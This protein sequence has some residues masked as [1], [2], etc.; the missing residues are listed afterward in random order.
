MK[1]LLRKVWPILFL[2]GLVVIFN[3]KYFFKGLIP[4]PGD[5]LVGAYFPWL[6]YKWG[7][8]VGVAIKNT[9]ISD[10]FSEFYM[11]KVNIA[12]AIVNHQ[13]PAWDPYFYSGFPLFAN[14]NIGAF[15]PFNFLMII[16]NKMDG[17]S[18]LVLSQSLFSSI[19]MY[20]FLKKI[21]KNTY[22]SLIGSIIYAFGGFA[23]AWSQFVNVGFAMIWL[24]LIFFLI[25]QAKSKKNYHILLFLTPL[26]FLTV[27]AGHFQALVYIVVLTVL[28]FVF[29]IGIKN[30]KANIYFVIASI[31]AI[32]VSSIQLLPT[33]ELL[34]LSIR[35]NDGSIR[36]CNFG[37]LPK[38][39]LITLIAPDYFGNPS[40]GNFWGFYNY[41]ETITYV[42]ILSLI[43]W[44]YGIYNYKKLKVG[45][46]FVFSSV[47]A[48]L[49][50][51][52]T[53]LG[54]AV[55]L[56]K[57]PFLWTSVAGRVTMVFL[58]SVSVLTALL[59]K[60]LESLKI[61]DLL[62]ILWAPVLLLT[63]GIVA[64]SH[65]DEINKL[66]ALRNLIL[67]TGLILIISITLIAGTKY[68]FLKY[69]L[70]LIV[71]FDLF[72]FGWKYLPFVPKTYIFPETDI[73]S[74]LKQD[75]TVFRVDKE[76]GPILPPNTWVGYDLM[77][78]SGYDPLAVT[79]YVKAYDYDL[80]GRDG[81]VSRYS[82]IDVYG[83]E[84]L[85]E[86]NVK[87]LLAVKRDEKGRVPGNNVD[88]RIGKDEWKRVFETPSVAVLQNTKYKK[89][90]RIINDDGTDAHGSVEIK[91]YENNK[92]IIDFENL[93]GEKLLL[94]D[95]Y[96]PGWVATINGQKVKIGNEIKPF[97]T[98]N[99]EDVKKGRV[100]FEYKPESYILGVK[101][102]LVSLLGWL[103]AL[104][105]GN[106]R[107]NIADH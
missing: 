82:E 51:F 83:A 6:E 52:D 20:V 46:F 30:T 62:K 60:N 21:V 18:L 29:R 36:G 39:N 5:L 95:T 15:N 22:A 42:G 86:Y 17:W 43:G 99:I 24:P 80:N 19:A 59:I 2:T 11:G 55:Y 84:A 78:P 75:K 37:L 57:V 85:A 56:Y 28:Y 25:E 97:R 26:F 77:S 103:L 76:R 66:V 106:W 101:I 9:L 34:N 33:I 8:I 92:I 98:L 10:I 90:V 104:K 88:Y 41:H 14:F 35:F 70:I 3:W 73:T 27:V 79:E 47:I 81:G 71:T 63:A 89:R 61:K 50:Q 49:F 102:A 107:K 40:T 72:R 100:V 12:R 74:F 93:D 58:F 69:V 16:T 13:W 54:K 23:T 45:K 94:S 67:P 1:K 38:Q 65:L 48:I 64:S 32:G 7:N 87:Y 44:I 91:N 31:L 105:W 96:Y 53:W 4:F 68:K